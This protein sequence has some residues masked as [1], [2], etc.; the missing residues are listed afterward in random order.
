MTFAVEA[1]KDAQ[2]ALARK[3]KVKPT[4]PHGS[5]EAYTSNDQSPRPHDAVASSSTIRDKVSPAPT[6]QK[7][8][9]ANTYQHINSPVRDLLRLQEEEQLLLREQQL[10]RN[11]ESLRDY[12]YVSGDAVD[13]FV[14]NFQSTANRQ[15]PPYFNPP[16]YQSLHGSASSYPPQYMP[17]QQ[18][19]YGMPPPQHYVHPSAH[20]SFAHQAHIHPGY[21]PPP[22]TIPRYVESVKDYDESIVSESRLLPSNPWSSSDMLS[23]L[24]PLG[25][26]A[27]TKPSRSVQ[28]MD[29]EK[30][31]ASN[32]LLMYLGQRTPAEGAK[33]RSTC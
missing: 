29:M 12:K 2:E 5:T 19:Y 28:R 22:V 4:N 32:S 16:P 25:A 11:S 10:L 8:F 3:R 18:Q 31:L 14:Q 6:Q 20:S 7:N 33:V 26:S 21:G 1:E 30:S 17:V 15:P 24:V 27:N 13:E 23:S 9:D